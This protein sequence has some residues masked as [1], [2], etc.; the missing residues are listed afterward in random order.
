M[1]VPQQENQNL[2][3]LDSTTRYP[4]LSLGPAQIETVRAGSAAGGGSTFNDFAREVGLVR[5]GEEPAV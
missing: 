3:R 2:A 1:K 4:K 5:H